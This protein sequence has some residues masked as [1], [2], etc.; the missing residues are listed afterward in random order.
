M[1]PFRLFPVVL[2]IA[3][4]FSFVSAC[5]GGGGGGDQ[6]TTYYADADGD[7][8]GDVNVSQ[9]LDAP[10]AGWVTDST[11]CDDTVGPGAAIN[12]GADELC[13]G[14][15]N[16]CSDATAD[17]AD[18]ATLGSS[19]DGADADLC[20]EGFLEC[21]GAAMTCSDLTGDNVETCNGLDDDCDGEVDE[22]FLAGGSVTYTDWDGSPLVKDDTCGTGDCASG[23]VVCAA[24]GLTLECSTSVNA[25]AE[26]CD[27][28]DNDC[29]GETDE[30][31]AG[32][33]LTQACYTGAPATR[34]VG[35]C[36]DGTQT[37][38]GGDWGACADE[39]VP[40]TEICDGQDNDC[41]SSTDETFPEQGQPCTVS[42]QQGTCA[43]STYSTC[44]AG[45]L[46]CPQTV[47]PVAETCNGLDDDCNGVTDNGLI[48]PPCPNQTGV[49]AGSLATCGGVSGW[50]ACDASNYGP[51]YES[52]ETTCDD[53]DNDCDGEVD[54]GIFCPAS[55]VLDDTFG[56]DVNPADGTPDGF[57]V[58]DGAD[59]GGGSL[60]NDYGMGVVSGMSGEV[61]GAGSYDLGENDMALWRYT[62]SGYLDSTFGPDAHP[63]DGVADGFVIYDKGSYDTGY[64]A[65]QDLSGRVY[66]AGHTHGGSSNY[67]MTI[68]RYNDAGVLD[69][70]FGTNG[71]VIHDGAAGG[72]EDHGV[73]M[74]LDQAGRIYVAG[75]SLDGSSVSDMIIWRYTSS[76][77]LDSTFGGDV[78]PADGTPD[79]FV[80]YNGSGE[81]YYG[82]GVASDPATGRVYV[83][84]YR[85]SISKDMVL[86]CFNGAGVLDTTFDGDGILIVD[87]ASAGDNAVGL[88]VTLDPSGRIYVAGSDESLVNHTDSI[89]WR[90]TMAGAL[91]TT[92]GGDTSPADGTPDGFVLHGN[93]AGGNGIDEARG[94]ALDLSG[95][96]Y[97][98]G[99]SQGAN[100]DMVL[101]RYTENG[102]L[103]TTFGGDVNPADG[104]PD[105]FV[106]QSGTAG[107]NG[108]DRGTSVAVGI[109]DSEKVYVI[110]SSQNSSAN[111]DM[112][113]WR[114]K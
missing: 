80:A 26:A 58:F 86:L 13:D 10:Q 105:G 56:D 54:N 79:G 49:C 12:P 8:Y 95:R 55:G 102:V 25:S 85:N 57:A 45:Q 22:D 99:N 103:D 69:T 104:T 48:A 76:G 100:E 14:V 74:T 51:N 20:E 1:R 78:N 94:I 40:T 6:G 39:V 110:G 67:D 42:G 15:D 112:V 62:S 16:D 31:S 65:A 66:L 93:A 32:V 4:A 35:E 47:F 64:A 90:F 107:G 50:L 114:F 30:A 19:C 60:H 81:N 68:L 2:I 11:D 96:I 41:D 101:W 89:I 34:N 38:S 92:F 5:G 17:G 111:Y 7:G 21:S 84:G 97:V 53:L 9:V 113:L 61:Y 91:D 44:T 3:A 33:P 70:S 87:G 23:T 109:V 75:Y 18:E 63:A 27:G 82:Q 106:V 83:A 108:V 59:Y 24:G 77:V 72:L 88:A 36:T 46:V 52:T 28:A 98:T 43:Q 37:C 71:V 29:D 73:A